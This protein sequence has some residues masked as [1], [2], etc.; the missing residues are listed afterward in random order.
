MFLFVQA[1]VGQIIRD[2]YKQNMSVIILLIKYLNWK[3][4]KI[5]FCNKNRFIKFY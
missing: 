4:I 2:V 3:Y 5:I 1:L